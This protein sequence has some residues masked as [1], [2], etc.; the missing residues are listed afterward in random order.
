MGHS[1]DG[2][3]FQID[4]NMTIPEPYAWS[5]PEECGLVNTTSNPLTNSGFIQSLCSILTVINVDRFT[6]RGS[7][8]VN[9]F[10]FDEHKQPQPPAG[11]FM[12]NSTNILV[13]DLF[14]NHIPG[15]MFIWNSQHVMVRKMI[16]WSHS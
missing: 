14:L 11:F 7:G 8:G 16:N 1:Y 5:T 10:L 2:V 12:I 9:G 15:M 13:E 3:T 6:F 4:G